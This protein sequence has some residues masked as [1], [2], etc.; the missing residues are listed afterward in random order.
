MIVE[1]CGAPGVGKSTLMPGIT[2]DLHRAG[3]PI[4]R[5]S[6]T[7]ADKAAAF[8]LFLVSHPGFVARS[9]A[10]IAATRQHT[11]ADLSFVTLT[12]LKRACRIGQQRN[13]SELE[14]V[15]AGIVQAL[16]S[17]G[18]RARA[19]AMIARLGV[20]M[21][22]PD[23]VIFVDANAET[24][25]RRLALREGAQSRLERVQMGPS[26]ALRIVDDVRAVL[27][28]RAVPFLQFANDCDSDRDRNATSIAHAI[29]AAW[30]AR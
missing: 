11:A 26:H 3:I 28:A 2:D 25:S 19:P 27:K 1:L 10:G 20:M 5:P 14:L 6:A 7:R 24:M 4:A 13:R 17:I 23:L 9:L 8:A 21:P 16:W 18:F 12:W 29:A 30:S 15:D 22:L